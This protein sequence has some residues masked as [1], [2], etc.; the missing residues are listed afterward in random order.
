M[1]PAFLSAISSRISF[2]DL[3]H[4]VLVDLNSSGMSFYLAKDV[5]DMASIDFANLSLLK[6]VFTNNICKKNFLADEQLFKKTLN[7]NLKSF[8]LSH[9]A[10]IFLLSPDCSDLEKKVIQETIFSFNEIFF[11]DRH[12]FYNFYLMQKRNFSKAKFIMNLFNDCAELSFF[13]QDK[14]LAYEKI[15]LR[16]LA[17]DSKNFIKKTREQS[18]FEQPDCFYFFTNN[19]VEKPKAVSL[20]QYLKLEAIE[21]QNLC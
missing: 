18:V 12:F 11:V 7:D 1:T 13:N 9:Y 21:I 8:I 20:A 3:K 17:L 5:R 4:L 16:N 15:Y 2:L 6:S 10:L 19:L 14:L